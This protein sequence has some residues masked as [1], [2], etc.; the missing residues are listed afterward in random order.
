MVDLTP[1]SQLFLPVKS[2]V[3][4]A[5]LN[6]TNSIIGAGIIGLPYA[7]R[8][9]GF[10]FGLVLLVALAFL[11]AWTVVLLVKCGKMVSKESYQDLIGAAFGGRGR[12]LIAFF[13]F[14]F[15]FG[16]MCAYIVIVGDTLPTVLV[17]LLGVA[18]DPWYL[19]RTFI[20]ILTT[21]CVSLPLSMQRDMAALAKTS[22]VSMVAIGFILCTVVVCAVTLPDTLRGDPAAQFTIIGDAP[23]KAIGVIS[24]AFV[25]HHNTF[26][27]FSSLSTPTL[28]RFS[29]VTYFSAGISLVA[30]LV[31]AITGYMTFTSSTQGNVLNN[32]P[33][34]STAI[35]FARLA[36]A[37]NMFTT[38]PMELFVARHVAEGYFY[39]TRRDEPGVGFVPLVN[40]D[41]GDR[42]LPMPAESPWIRHAAWTAG[43]SLASLVVA[44]GVQD[45]SVV[46][47]AT[48][49]VAASALAYI[50]PPW[51]WLR[52]ARS[53]RKSCVACMT[54]GIVTMVLSIVYR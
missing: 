4:G 31:L 14:I 17:A 54:F 49:G 3:A 52:V 8:Q 33:A 44:V 19:S 27:I 46:L 20:M 47:E 29:R 26:I 50:L 42:P 28:A 1:H 25:C 18:G 12:F 32:F 15:A 51:V 35:N 48:G 41:T 43:L 2:S 36:F 7:F 13:Q 30:C 53:S 34:D 9:A 6:F 24:F 38:F 16:A 23:F 22:A 39:P 11:V 21:L 10:F 40:G 37:L 45:V 5:T